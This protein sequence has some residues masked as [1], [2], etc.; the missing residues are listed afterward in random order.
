MRIVLA[1]RLTLEVSHLSMFCLISRLSSLFSFLFV[2]GSPPS[3]YW[4][5]F[6]RP[7][8][9]SFHNNLPC[10]TLS[11]HFYGSKITHS[12]HN[13]THSE[14]ARC[15]D[16]KNKHIKKTE[17]WIALCIND[18]RKIPIKNIIKKITLIQELK[19]SPTH[20]CPPRVFVAVLLKQLLDRGLWAH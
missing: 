2:P 4:F 20:P 11:M 13:H 8:F 7:V 9:F 6:N 10:G 18:N 17:F 1:T 3:S 12:K 14:S 15:I 16:D 19:F 5:F